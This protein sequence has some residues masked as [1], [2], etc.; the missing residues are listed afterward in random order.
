MDSIGPKIITR[1]T[2]KQAA[3]D[4]R[5]ARLRAHNDNNPQR[6]A[7]LEALESG[8]IPN[9]SFG[10]QV[11]LSK[12]LRTTSVNGK[13]VSEFI[14]TGNIGSK[15]LERQRYEV[16]AGRDEEPL[17]F[18]LIYNVVNDPMLP[19]TVQ[20]NTLKAA[21]V[22]FTDVSEGGEV[23]FASIS[24]SEKTATLVRRAAGIEYDQD[25]IDYNELFRLPF[26]ERQ[27]GIAANA[28]QNHIHMQP[29]LTASYV[30]AN[31]TAASAV[32]STLQEKYHNTLDAAI[33]HSRADKTFPRRGPYV[34]LCAIENLSMMRMA[35]TRVPQQTFQGQSPEVFDRIQAVVAYD[36]WSGTRGKAAAT[37]YTGVAA[38]KAYLISLQFRDEDL[39]SWYKQ[40]LTQQRG[41]GDMSRFVVE[42]VI[43][44]MIFG[45]YANP[46]ACVEEITLPTS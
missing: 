45:V 20:I 39:Q 4:R 27:F 1:E 17:L 42:Q 25:I 24:S 36:G 30:S 32:G 46:R 3:I 2:L 22:V 44:S 23:K 37:S 19:R 21:G 16:A 18:P 31:Q 34:V 33:A 35:T 12:L 6:F 8:T 7:A 41:D 15:W 40:Q 43:W 11:N 13:Q 10:E 26:L 9:A 5:I 14:G 29:I 28:L 38:N